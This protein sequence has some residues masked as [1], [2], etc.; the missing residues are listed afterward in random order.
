MTVKIR[1]ADES[2][3]N[4]MRKAWR[5][6]FQY[7]SLAVDGAD[8]SHYFDEMTR[9]FAAIVPTASARIACDP[10]DD[11]VRVGFACWTGDVLHYIYVQRDFRGHA[12]APAMLEGLPIKAYSFTT[13]QFVKRL[14]P[15]LRGWAFK[16]RFTYGS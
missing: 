4:Y 1:D 14:K 2:D 3:W 13:L 5:E 15:L 12:L 16:P 6:T 7:G 11:D 9:L 8:K 10:T